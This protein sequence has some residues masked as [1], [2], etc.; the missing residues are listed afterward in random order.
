MSWLKWL[1]YG[2]AIGFDL[3]KLDL[4]IVDFSFS[5]HMQAN[6]LQVILVGAAL[7]LYK[8]IR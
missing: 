2:D 6:V 8:K 3:T 7:L 1:T 4:A 5:F